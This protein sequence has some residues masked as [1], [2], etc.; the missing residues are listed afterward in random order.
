LRLREQDAFAL[1]G[2]D[3]PFVGRMRLADVNDEELD[4]I[5]EAAMQRL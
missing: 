2:F 5:A 4:P 1:V 3:L